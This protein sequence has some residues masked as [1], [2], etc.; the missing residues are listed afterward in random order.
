GIVADALLDEVL[1]CLDVVVGGGF[2]RLDA[3]AFLDREA[4]GDG[5][6]LLDLGGG[7]RRQFRDARLGGQRQQPFDLHVY[8]AVHQA[9]LAED[10]AQR[11]DLAG[12]TAVQRRQGGEGVVGHRGVPARGNRHFTLTAARCPDVYS[13]FWLSSRRRPGSSEVCVRSTRIGFACYARVIKLDDQP[14]AVEKRLRPAPE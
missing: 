10:R 2:D 3:G 6:Q 14:A 13:G 11:L 12:I 5:M 4:V 8:A 9:E 1:H 7:E